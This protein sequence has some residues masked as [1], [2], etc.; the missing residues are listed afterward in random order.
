VL[1]F[2]TIEGARACGLDAK[3]GSI[4][5]G[6]DADIVLLRTDMLNVAPVND[7]VAAVVLHADTSNV[8][9]VLVRGRFVKREGRM[10][11]DNVQPLLEHAAASRDRLLRHW[12]APSTTKDETH[13]PLSMR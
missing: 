6:K 10:L 2:A 1:E 4:S 7:P 5:P 13:D 11:C 9:S 3:I 12:D 8:D